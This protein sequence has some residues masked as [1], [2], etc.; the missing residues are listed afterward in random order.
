MK[1]FVQRVDQTY[2]SDVLSSQKEAK[3]KSDRKKR[4]QE[5]RK[6]KKLAKK[7]KEVDLFGGRDFDDL[8]DK[9]KFGEVV[10]APPTLNKVPKA[11]GRGKE[12]K[13]TS[14]TY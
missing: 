4:N 10:D 13:K 8:E 12:V 3:V 11:R 14:R 5:T 9:V 6:Q 7:Q 1:D 2:R